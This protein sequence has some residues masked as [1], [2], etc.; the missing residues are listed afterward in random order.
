MVLK[1]TRKLSTVGY[2]IGVSYG[3]QLSKNILLTLLNVPASAS[4]TAPVSQ[5]A[6]Y[7]RLFKPIKRLLQGL[8]AEHDGSGQAEN[9]R[10]DGKYVRR[11]TVKNIRPIAG[12][13]S[14]SSSTRLIHPV[15]D[16]EVMR[17]SIE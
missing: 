10:Q 4:D 13:W 3:R 11:D 2:H 1:P 9:A 12:V 8:E 17:L 14:V 7:E 16:F 5:V 6:V 15:A